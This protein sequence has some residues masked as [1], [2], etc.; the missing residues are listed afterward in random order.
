L[1]GGGKKK[2][3]GRGHLR[4]GGEPKKKSAGGSDG[5]INGMLLDECRGKKGDGEERIQGIADV[6]WEKGKLESNY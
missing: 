2:G 3:A 1:G 5:F 6:S 4:K